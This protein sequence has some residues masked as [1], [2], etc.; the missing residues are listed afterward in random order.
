MMWRAL[1]LFMALTLS[2]CQAGQP[3]QIAE[4]G[5]EAGFIAMWAVVGSTLGPV[6]T[7][8]GGMLGAL[9]MEAT[10]SNLELE[11]QEKRT[12][13]LTYALISE[14]PDA[15]KFIENQAK[16]VALPYVWWGMGILVLIYVITHPKR[17]FGWITKLKSK[18][19][20]GQA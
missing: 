19:N 10:D 12:D 18:Q 17:F 7:L 6:G 13:S 5:L 9:W 2:G 3:R 14:D 15:R 16:E 8:V 4:E 20:D 1:I 11:H